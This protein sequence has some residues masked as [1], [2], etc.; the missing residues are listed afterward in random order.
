[1]PNSKRKGKTGEL[2]AAKVLESVFGIRA[3]RSVQ[4][5]GDEGH[6][7]IVTEPDIGLFIEVKRCERLNVF[8]AVDKAAQQANGRVPVIL[9]RKNKSHWLLV[10]KLQDVPQFVNNV[11][12]AIK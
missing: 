3:R 7:D 12:D 10:L 4:Y 5:C 9:W 2:E 6:A 1:M 11:A 8:A